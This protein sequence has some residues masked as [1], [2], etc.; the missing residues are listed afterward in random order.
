MSLSQAK[1]ALY[2]AM[3]KS[4]LCLTTPVCPKSLRVYM[5]AMTSYPKE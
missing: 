3:R 2:W 4:R 1:R 5:L